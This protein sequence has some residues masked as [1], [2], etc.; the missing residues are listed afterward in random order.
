[1][2]RRGVIVGRREVNRHAL[3]GVD[4]LQQA[5][6][7][8]KA[9]AEERQAMGLGNDEV[10]GEQRDPARERLTDE[11]VGLGMVLVARAAQRDPSAAIDEQPCGGGGGGARD[12]VPATRQRTSR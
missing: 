12:T 4:A 6:R 2:A 10:R 3:A 11:P 9:S 7:G 1:M 8:L 5:E